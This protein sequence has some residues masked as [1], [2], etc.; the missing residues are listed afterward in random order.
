M[1]LEAVLNRV[2]S[3]ALLLTSPGKTC[4]PALF[5][6]GNSSDAT[7]LGVSPLFNLEINVE[8]AVFPHPTLNAQETRAPY[9]FALRTTVSRMSLAMQ[10]WYVLRSDVSRAEAVAVV[11][12]KLYGTSPQPVVWHKW[13]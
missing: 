1:T 2:T 3:A 11:R 8:D 6:L 4:P 7:V 10:F 13:P 9:W 5:H 12:G